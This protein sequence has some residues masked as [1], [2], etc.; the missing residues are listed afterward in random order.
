VI[1]DPVGATTFAAEAARLREGG[2]YV[3][4]NIGFGDAVRAL[5][6]RRAPRRVVIGVSGDTRDDLAT[7]A[8]MVEAGT[9][10]PVVD[11]VYPLDGIAEAHREVERRHRRGTIVVTLGGA[12]SSASSS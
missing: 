8:G 5:T 9:V 11:R 2:V 7:I 1:L 3:P 6:T 4:L 12:Q 10:R